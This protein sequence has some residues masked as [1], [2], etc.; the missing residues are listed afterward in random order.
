M[1]IFRRCV[2]SD[3]LEED[4]RLRHLLHNRDWSSPCRRWEF[5][6][7]HTT[8]SSNVFRQ[9]ISIDNRFVVFLFEAYHFTRDVVTQRR[10]MVSL[11]V[12]GSPVLFSLLKR[13]VTRILHSGLPRCATWQRYFLKKLPKYVWFF[14]MNELSYILTQLRNSWIMQLSGSQGSTTIDVAEG[15]NHMTLDVIGLAGK[16]LRFGLSTRL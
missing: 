3:I 1:A 11:L 4:S 8:T 2:T 5:W 13:S 7:S 10:I 15:L 9:A 16:L 12:D 6:G 14:F